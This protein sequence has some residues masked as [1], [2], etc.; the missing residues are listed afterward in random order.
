LKDF[1]DA[2]QADAYSGFVHL[3]GD[4]AVYEVA[5]LAHVRRHFHH[6]HNEVCGEELFAN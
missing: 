5:Y 3:Y 2:L 1:K 6:I 4:L